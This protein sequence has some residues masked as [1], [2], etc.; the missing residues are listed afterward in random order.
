MEIFKVIIYMYIKDLRIEVD[1]KVK[2]NHI[3]NLE[4]LQVNSIN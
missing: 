4:N 1:H 3:V 2:V